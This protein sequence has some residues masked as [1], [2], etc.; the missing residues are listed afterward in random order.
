MNDDRQLEE[1]LDRISGAV[2]RSGVWE[3]IEAGATARTRRRGGAPAPR[4]SCLRVAAFA[5]AALVL[6]AAISVGAFEAVEHLGKVSPILHIGDE[7]TAVMPAT[8]TQVPTSTTQPA[9]TTTQAVSTTTEAATTTTSLEETTT[10]T[11]KLST[12]ETRLPN[13]HIKAMGFI[14]KVYVKDGKRYI[15]IDYAEYLTGA[16]AD[17]AAVA[18]GE[19]KPGEHVEDDFWIRNDNPQKRVFEV[20]DSVAITTS[21]WISTFAWN[22]IMGHPVTWAQF[23]NFWS[24]TPPDD[25]INLH[26]SPW[27]IE[28][29]GLVVVKIDEQFLP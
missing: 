25:G 11:E 10:T 12:A 7:T 17:A 3:S 4:R 15:S 22:E 29:E 20:S 13:G 6:A 16:A 26:T 24:A 8:T 9:T 21:T 28:R 27:W 2:D 14:D 5:C 1:T 19:I 18:A 23:K